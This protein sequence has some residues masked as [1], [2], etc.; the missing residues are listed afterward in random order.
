MDVTKKTRWQEKREASYEALVAA[1]MRCF[2][3]RGY[4]ATRLEDIVQA[5]G[6]TTGA[7]YFHFANKADCFWHVIAYRERLRGDWPVDLLDGLDPAT[8]SLEQVLEKVFARFAAADQGLGAWVLVMVDF[9]QQHRDDPDT[10]A[11]L[12]EVYAGWQGRI[13]HFVTVLQ[14]RGWIAADRDPDQLARLAFA[15][16]EGL[17]VHAE[18]YTSGRDG[19]IDG[20]ARLLRD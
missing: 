11:K 1:A 17:T 7:F 4:A 19:L 18:L 20:L 13:G 5:A 2:H 3:A 9:H 14:Q 6:Y 16:T 8:T 10:Q 12:A 15:F